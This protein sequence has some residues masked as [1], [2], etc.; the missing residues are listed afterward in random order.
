MSSEI[1]R[2]QVSWSSESVHHG[3]QLF[4]ACDW[5]DHSLVLAVQSS[6][7]TQQHDTINRSGVGPRRVGGAAQSSE[8]TSMSSELPCLVAMRQ[9][10]MWWLPFFF[11]WLS[12]PSSSSFWRLYL[13][14]RFWNHTLTCGGG[15]VSEHTATLLRVFQLVFAFIHQVT[16][17]TLPMRTCPS[18]PWLTHNWPVNS[19]LQDKFVFVC[20]G[21]GKR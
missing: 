7:Y 6:N 18:Q 14:L 12:G 9:R 15:V 3:T 19:S 1:C 16:N 13:V 2:T 21:D 8:V 20:G 10:L 17:G 4:P 11:C 5:A